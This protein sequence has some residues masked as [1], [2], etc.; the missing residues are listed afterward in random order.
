MT[1]SVKQTAAVSSISAVLLITPACVH[2]ASMMSILSELVKKGDIARLEIVNAEQEADWVQNLGIRSVPWL[3]LDFVQLPGAYSEAEI[4]QWLEKIRSGIAVKEYLHM[5]LSS[6]QLESV[7]TLVQSDKKF[8]LGLLDLLSDIT[9]DL[10]IKLGIA[11]VMENIKGSD[12][13]RSNLHE[14]AAL[15]QNDDMNSRIDVLYYI[16]LSHSPEAL[17]YVEQWLADSN[18]AIVEAAKEA[19]EELTKL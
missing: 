10:K 4:L 9:L 11:T 5:S 8:F 17:P 2:C 15:L 12:T 3:K 19:L 13:L 6:G 14:L 16:S 18:P 1:S 7:T